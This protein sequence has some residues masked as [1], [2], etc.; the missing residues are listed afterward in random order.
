MLSVGA[1][2]LVH[3]RLRAPQQDRETLVTPATSQ[4]ASGAQRFLAFASQGMSGP[5]GSKL[6]AI[7]QQA[8][9]EAIRLAIQYTSNYQDTSWT[10]SR[11][12]TAPLIVGGH[13]PYLYHPGVWLKN[14]QLSAVAEKLQ[15]LA[16]NWIVDN[17]TA[18]PAEVRVPWVK[19]S[20]NDQQ[21]DFGIT[22][23]P[24]DH[25]SEAMPYEERFV[26]D[27]SLFTT[28]AERL[29]AAMPSQ[30]LDG[31]QPLIHAI[32][33][34]ALQAISHQKNC[35]A[36]KI[37]LGEVLA[38]ARH[39]IEFQ[40]GVR[41]LE[42]P[43]SWIS[44]TRSYLHFSE[45]ILDNLP[46]FAGHYNRLLAHY[47]RVNK[48][49]ST[50]HPMPDLAT[51]GDWHEAPFWIWTEDAPRRE[52][53]FLRN[54][55]GVWALSNRKGVQIELDRT[56]ADPSLIFG[57]VLEQAE[58]AGIKIRPRAIITTLF[59]RLTLGDAFIHGI[60]GAKY[61]ELTDAL[62][63]DFFEVEPP[64]YQT[65]T[66]TVRLPL[67]FDPHAAEQR[68]IHQRHLRD[69]AY[70]GEAFY[71]SEWKQHLSPQAWDRLGVLAH[72]KK[73]WISASW[74]PAGKG[75][76]HHQG[77]KLNQQLQDVLTPVT[78]HLLR[79]AALA[80][81]RQA[82]ARVLGSREFSMALFDQKELP[83][84]LLDFCKL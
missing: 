66:A 5:W 21:P 78:Q 18:G 35:H 6:A 53:L 61:D 20:A 72:E 69:I 46:T 56:V 10:A 38:Q 33:H 84:L 76:W 70:R 13:Q 29:V 62:M 60:G 25:G 47:R 19:P 80:E 11:S 8:R 31:K 26:L 55:K 75:A 45:L 54:H 44:R 24:I 23:V 42:L 30:L 63:R 50:A 15:G 57:D 68:E 36:G 59:S 51:D 9:E 17:D 16:I 2:H 73:Q 41:T 34:E 27:E 28:F 1:Q 48:I 32:W 4:I 14:F 77:Q 3:R 74:Q 40:N 67:P 71:S 49:R 65:V 83:H 81:R 64:L 58:R 82:A 22:A 12:A 79:E 37:N 43:L 52:R 39:Q 7:R